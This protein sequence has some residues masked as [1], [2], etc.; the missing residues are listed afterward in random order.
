VRP[1]AGPRLPLTPLQS[2]VTTFQGSQGKQRNLPAFTRFHEGSQL[3]RTD[4]YPPRL[5][6]RQ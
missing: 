4:D 3:Q 1:K 5:P 6:P 2:I